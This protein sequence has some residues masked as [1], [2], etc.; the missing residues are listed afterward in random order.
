MNRK[1]FLG[2]GLW[3]GLFVS[4]SASATTAKMSL[5]DYLEQVKKTSPGVAAS[6][7]QIEGTE[8]TAAEGNL[9]YVPKFSVTGNYTD[10][11]REA[12]NLFYLGS[13]SS[14]SSLGFGL[15]KQFAF[16]TN[17]KLSYNI[18][19]SLTSGLSTPFPREFRFSQGQT[20]L[21]VSQPL[22][23]NGFGKETRATA[24]FAEASSLVA[25]Y[26]EKF[27]LKQALSQAET[28]YY[29]LAIAR[30][31]LRLQEELLDRAK[32]LLEW[33]DRRMKNQLADKSD[34]L[35]AKAAFQMRGLEMEAI[36]GE[37]RSAQLA[38]NSLRN[39]TSMEVGETLDPINTQSLLS[40][41]A[42][43]RAQVTDDLKAAEQFE[44][45][46][47][48]TNELSRQRAQPELALTGTVAYNGVDTFLSPAMKDSFTTKHP[49]YLIA[50]KF[51]F[52]I[53][54]WETSEIRS[55]RVRQQ[56]A[57]EESTRQ[58]RLT[59]DQTWQDLSKKFEETKHRLGLAE[60]L[61]SAQK[62][63]LDHEKYRF[64]LGRTT[65]FQVVT[66]EQDYAQSLI[67][68]TRIAQEFLAIRAQMKPYA[69]E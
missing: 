44:R 10:D 60:T 38:F 5:N 49:L 20:Q 34:M 2:S 17:A 11:R 57:A 53:Y 36:K 6:N 9:T 42:L 29:R 66:Y 37:L 32:K 58:A 15:E 13:T 31:S 55:G 39:S 27:K 14:G 54:F 41:P 30:D 45:V 19:N 47:V 22:W 21:D 63:K 7:L 1:S 24:D 18:T 8:K 51:S 23:K 67:T 59:N 52:P 33:A 25:H 69:E 12:A 62:E 4:F 64:G 16:G 56:L 3:L 48:S 26:S 40:T 28:T 35:Q 46:V 61:V 43:K 50:V 68:R 65:T